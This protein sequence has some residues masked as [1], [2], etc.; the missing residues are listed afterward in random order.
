MRVAD[1]VDVAGAGNSRQG[2][3]RIPVPHAPVG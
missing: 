1:L 3:P 2:A